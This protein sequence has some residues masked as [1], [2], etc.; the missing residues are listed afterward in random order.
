M[1]LV[2][3][4]KRRPMGR[5]LVASPYGRF[6][7]LPRVLAESGH[8]VF[9]HL[10]SYQRESDVDTEIGGVR[11]SSRSAIPTGPVAY[12]KSAHRLV[13]EVQPDWVVGLSDTYFGIV[14]HR[15]ATRHHVRFAV[16]AYDNFEAYFP[17]LPPVHTRWRQALEA[18]DLVT[19]AG[20]AL[21]DFLVP[22]SSMTR[23]EVV[24]MAA[25]PHWF[26]S[27]DQSEARVTL[28]LPAREKIIGYAGSLHSSRGLDVLFEATRQLA[29]GDESVRLVLAG[30]KA[31]GFRMPADALW[32]GSVTPEQVPILFRGLDVLAVMNRRSSFGDHSY[33][34]K[35]YEAMAVG[36]R[37]VATATPA[38]R[39][40]L[41]RT[42]ECLVGA[43]D[44]GALIE[45]VRSMFAADVPDYGPQ[46]G[47]DES[48][49]RL[50]HA[51]HQ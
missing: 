40:I 38:T 1:R 8:D 49:G 14:A 3:L 13:R 35:L 27:Y 20:P 28:G 44:V 12:M 2:F 22:E 26:Q 41:E 46:A 6:Y 4:S 33:P 47:W 7:H 36:T 32:L 50:E 23:A 17:R 48:A 15:L 11:V 21:L 29:E 16:D 19:A 31:R 51:L 5:D 37:V 39:W 45:R 24:P 34:V 18:A 43:E 10:L 30:R 42:P 25:D 9:L